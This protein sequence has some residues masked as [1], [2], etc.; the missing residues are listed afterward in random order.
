MP[1]LCLQTMLAK[2]KTKVRTRAAP[3][4]PSRQSGHLEMTS[5]ASKGFSLSPSH[6]ARTGRFDI[7]DLSK[8]HARLGQKNGQLQ[9]IRTAYD[10]CVRAGEVHRKAEP[11]DKVMLAKVLSNTGEIALGIGDLLWMKATQCRGGGG[12]R[13][14]RDGSAGFS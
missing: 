3:G 1:A 8:G 2:E 14:W 6:R 9:E 10:L 13:W 4:R 5:R 7:W 11:S 12:P